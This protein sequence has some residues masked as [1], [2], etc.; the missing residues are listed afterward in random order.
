MTRKRV[1]QKRGVKMID[2]KVSFLNQL[3]QRLSMEV[4]SAEMPKIM[5]A[6]ADIMEWF[7]INERAKEAD[8]TDDLLDCY[9]SALKVQGR[10]AKTLERYRYVIQRMMKA[11]NVTTRKITVYHLR[12]Y[13][14]DEKER[15]VCD[16][17]LE[18]IRQIFSAYFNWLQRESLIDRNPTANLGAI[19]RPKKEKKIF[20]DADMELMKRGSKCIR[21]RTIIC[22]LASSGCRVSE[23]T[24]L[25]R[26]NVDLERLECVVHGKGDKERIVYIDA[27]TAMLLRQYFATRKDMETALFVGKRNERLLPGGVRTMLRDIEKRTGVEHVHPHKFRRTF[28]TNMARRGMPIQEIAHLMGHEKIETTMQYIMLNRE[29]VKHDYRKYA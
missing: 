22:F 17:T 19:K 4:F 21:D 12:Q 10:S 9:I 1:K 18:G 14:A 3:E 25:D 6:V 13:L 23:L 24:E 29:D 20:T 7:D 28:A 8:A 27:V 26:K 11:V 16:E 2:S 15:G 5:K